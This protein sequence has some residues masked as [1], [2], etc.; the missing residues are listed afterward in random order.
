MRNHRI[1]LT[2]FALGFIATIANAESIPCD[3]N[4]VF[5]SN[6]AIFYCVENFNA[7]RI[8]GGAVEGDLKAISGDVEALEGDVVVNTGVLSG[9]VGALDGITLANFVTSTNEGIRDNMQRL[10]ENDGADNTNTGDY[11]VISGGRTNEITA[12]YAVVGG[13]A[14]NKVTKNFSTVS[15]GVVNEA[16][17]PHAAVG[18][19]KKNVVLSNGGAIAGGVFNTVTGGFST[20]AGGYGN[21]VIGTR[22][23]AAGA[24]MRVRGNQTFV[25]GHHSYDFDAKPEVVQS[26]MTPITAENAFIIYSGNVGINDINPKATLTVGEG[27]TALADSWLVRATAEE[28][29]VATLYAEGADVCLES[30]DDGCVVHAIDTRILLGALLSKV[31][32]LDAAVQDLK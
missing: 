16:N 12:N 25:W 6:G 2:L 24:N 19:G 9:V 31:A 18:G 5:Q 1:L 4:T 28:A 32:Q 14:S 23:V 26:K 15:G 8:D 21:E 11:S 20:V 7:V 29:A 27:K 22:S 13:G 17:G 3:R 10:D 30:N